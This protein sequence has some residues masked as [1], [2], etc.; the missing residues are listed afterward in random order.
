MS[1]SK[2]SLTIFSEKGRLPQIE[3][4]FEAVAKGETSVGT[5]IHPIHEIILI[6]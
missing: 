6:I 4:A 2:F 3:N 1:N 5:I